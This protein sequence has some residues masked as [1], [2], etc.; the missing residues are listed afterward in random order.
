MAIIDLSLRLI[1]RPIRT[2]LQTIYEPQFFLLTDL[3]LKRIKSGEEIFSY[4]SPYLTKLH[5]NLKS[6]LSSRYLNLSLL[7]V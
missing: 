1:S 5:K 6:S 7:I 3:I 2:A 4:L